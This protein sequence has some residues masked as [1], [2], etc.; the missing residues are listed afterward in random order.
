MTDDDSPSSAYAGQVAAIINATPRAS[1]FVPTSPV[2]LFIKHRRAPTS[3]AEL[4]PIERTQLER[5]WRGKDLDRLLQFG[6]EEE[7]MPLDIEVADVVDEHGATR[8]KMWASNYGVVFL[9]GAT[10][11]ECFAFASQH[12]VEHWSADQRD[13]FWAM[14]RALARGDHG[15]L[16]PLQFCWWNDDCW[17]RIASLPPYTA[18]SATHVRAQLADP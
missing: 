17:A 15:V 16:Q 7:D 12:H 8:Y 14:D 10:S 18:Y 11:C 9:L 13:L 4:S 2:E 5:M 3:L 1:S 6:D